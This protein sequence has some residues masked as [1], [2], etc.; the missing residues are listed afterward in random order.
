VAGSAS[1][2]AKNLSKQNLP[3]LGWIGTEFGLG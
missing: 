2:R 1:V 3:N